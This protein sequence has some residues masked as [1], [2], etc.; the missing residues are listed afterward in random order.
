MSD[1]PNPDEAAAETFGIEHSPLEREI[2]RD[3][4]RVKIIIYR[5]RGEPWWLLEIEH[6]DGG[7]T[8]WDERFDTDQAALD[9]ALRAID[10][11]GAGSFARMVAEATSREEWARKLSSSPLSDIRLELDSSSQLMGFQQT[12][13]VFA[14]VATAP[15]MVRSSAW[16]DL[17]KGEHAFD[18][19]D[20]VGRFTGGL[21]ALYNAVLQ[22]I[23]E[24]GA[25][26]CP[27]PND[28]AAVREFCEGYLEIALHDPTWEAN[29]RAFVELLPMMALAGLTTMDKVGEILPSAKADPESWLEEQRRALPQTVA[30]LYDYW[31]DRRARAGIPRFAQRVT[32]VRR[33]AAKVGRNDPCPCRSGK[34][35][36][37]CCAN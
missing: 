11:D 2:E 20:E 23:A 34:K 26:C 6:Q 17:I 25:H 13:G 37:K 4:A 18:S 22:S 21:M 29:E 3:G 8:E 14:A 33:D 28:V 32:P 5:D 24:E 1:S 30:S 36:K 10:E 35:F 7:C 19:I 27:D 16:L 9:E 12:C 15:E 31:R